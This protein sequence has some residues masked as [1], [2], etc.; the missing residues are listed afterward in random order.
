MAINHGPGARFLKAKQTGM[1]AAQMNISQE[2][3]LRTPIPV[4]PLGEQ[5]RIVAKVDALMAMLDALEMLLAKA[6][7]LQGQFANAA[8]HHLDV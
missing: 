8:V 7:E 5:H 6:R 2:R 1:D 4:P 3:L